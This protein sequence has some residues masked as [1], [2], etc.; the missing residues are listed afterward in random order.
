[1][2]MMVL[3]ALMVV[4]TATA[5]NDRV[6]L[7]SG[8]GSV[9]MTVGKKATLTI[10]YS[11]ATCDGK[12]LQ[13]YLKDCGDDYVR[14]WPGVRD[15]GYGAFVEKFNDKFEDGVQI[16]GSGGTLKIH[17]RVSEVDFGNTAL[18]VVFS[19]IGSVGGAAVSGTLTVTNASGKR[20][21]QFDVREVKG[22]GAADYTEGTR[23]STCLENVVKALYKTIQKEKK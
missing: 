2:M 14:D 17:F 16:V 18:S 1:M 12:P 5:K 13:K 19:G 15:K 21:A 20:L 10:D 7:T 6:T 22:N 9:L 8:D 4:M 11:C 3:T 23:L